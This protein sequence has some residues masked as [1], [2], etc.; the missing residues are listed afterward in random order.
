MKKNSNRNHGKALAQRNAHFS[1]CGMYTF[2]LA[3]KKSKIATAV[4]FVKSI[5]KNTA[6]K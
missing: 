4:G 2:Q 1:R 3:E 5:V 6:N